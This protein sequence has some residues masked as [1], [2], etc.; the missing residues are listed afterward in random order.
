MTKLFIEDTEVD[1]SDASI[2]ID[3]SIAK[4]GEIESRSGARSA[5][6]ALPKTANNRLVFENTEDVTSLSVKPYR[7][8]KARLFSDGIDQKI[9][10]ASLESISDTFNIRV[11]GENVSFYDLI[12]RKCIEL[13]LKEYDHFKTFAEVRDSRDNT[14]GY[15]YPIID[16]N[17]DSPNLYF[18]NATAKAYPQYLYPAP[19]YEDVIQKICENVGYT[20]DNRITDLPDYPADKICIPYSSVPYRRNEDMGRYE[21]SLSISPDFALGGDS[22]T[23]FVPIVYDLSYD[24]IDA[25]YQYNYWQDWNTMFFIDKVKADISI[26]FQLENT[27]MIDIPFT[28]GVVSP[29][30][31]SETYTQTIPAL[32]TVTITLNYT[33][34]DIDSFLQVTAAAN[35]ITVGCILINSSTITISNC[36]LV[37]FSSTMTYGDN[38]INSFVTL[39]SLLPDWKQSQVILNYLKMFCGL[40]SVNE[41]TKVVTL[42]SFGN[43]AKN[44]QNG[45]DWSDKIDLTDSPD[46]SFAFDYAQVNN[47]LYAEDETVVKPYNT[48][49]TILIDDENLEANGDMVKLDFAA[50]Q[51]VERLVGK[52]CSQIKMW[53]NV[54]SD[55]A[56]FETVKQRV[57]A[58]RFEDFSFTYNDGVTTD[59]VT[60]NIPLP[61][62]IDESNTLGLDFDLGFGSKLAQYYDSFEQV[63]DKSKILTINLRLN[64]SDINQLDF[65][66]P[67]FIK[68]FNA[69]FYISQ[70]K[71]YDPTVTDVTQ[72]E[73]VKLF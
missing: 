43:I 44:I 64:A 18:D 11:Y 1:L 14:T 52:Y 36:R 19:Y 15:L 67:V 17:A 61:Y 57:L 62:F 34:V 37:E 55:E 33:D 21:G 47:L 16:Y 35:N 32:T 25:S 29:S 54:G 72:C 22:G 23:P 27:L 71:G 20:L 12:Q 10:F 48:D 46:L 8:L 63:L 56:E 65:T 58:V 2:Q 5:Q 42:F 50:T 49:A 51:Q 39:S 13:D 7:R 73:L 38:N 31:F 30:G 66:K 3:Y 70:I 28:S 40:I 69:W 4:I 26:V 45:K 9:L 6:I 68:H 24:I 41:Q 53:R 59:T 60:T